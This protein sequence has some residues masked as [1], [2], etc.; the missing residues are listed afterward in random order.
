MRHILRMLRNGAWELSA[1]W[2]QD[3]G[4]ALQTWLTLPAER[5][6]GGDNINGLKRGASER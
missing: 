3:L 1:A 2:R 5:E 6:D 4:A